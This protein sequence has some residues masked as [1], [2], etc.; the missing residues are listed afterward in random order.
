MALHGC[1]AGGVLVIAENGTITCNNT[2]D[3]RLATTFSANLPMVCISSNLFENV[4]IVLGMQSYFNGVRCDINVW[5]DQATV[6][7]VC[8]SSMGW[9]KTPPLPCP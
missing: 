5:Q 8:I 9:S 3:A 7:A 6:E 1:S 4:I 2:L